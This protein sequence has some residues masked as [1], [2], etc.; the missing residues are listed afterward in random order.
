MA[1]LNPSLSTSNLHSLS[2]KTSEMDIR[3][4]TDAKVVDV[5]GERTLNQYA[6]KNVLG[7]GSYGTVYRAEDTST[8][9][10]VAIKEMDARKL[11]RNK[12]TKAG[13]PFGPR[14]RFRGRGGG[15][16]GQMHSPPVSSENPIDLVRG[17]IA[18]MKK[19]NH[20]NVVK[21]FE[22]LHDPNQDSLFM[23]YEICEKGSLMDVSMSNSTTPYSEDESRNYFGQLILGIEYHGTLKIV[24]FG[25]SEMFS[26][27]NDK[28][29]NSAGSPAFFAPEMCAVHHGELSARATDIWA[30]GVTL[31]CLLYGFVPFK[32]ESIIKL[33][34]SIQFSPIPFPADSS[35]NLTLANSLL[36]RIL[37]KI[38]ETRIHMD[39]LRIHPWVTKNGQNPLISKEENFV[40]L[41]TGVTEEDVANAVKSVVPVWT[42]MR[43]VQKFK[44]KVTPN[45]SRSN[46][47]LHEDLST[48][49]PPPGTPPSATSSTPTTSAVPVIATTPV[50]TSPSKSTPAVV[51]PMLTFPT[52]PV[53]RSPRSPSS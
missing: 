25:V 26:S 42:I 39:D 2:R 52:V 3:E 33:Y 5:S 7:R 31:F 37:D 53:A 27:G 14:G 15:A 4:T 36:E 44:T 46:L 12:L 13:G 43:A 45:S 50:S 17:E 30:M 20:V 51:T 48:L 38:P 9:Q 16:A 8:G 10:M 6:I 40:G 11:K 41:V 23:V 34:E 32:G 18:I 28:S 29:K 1:S 47:N 49:M 19:L 24:D 21:L 35:K 22:V